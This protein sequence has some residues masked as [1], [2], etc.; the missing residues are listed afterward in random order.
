MHDLEEEHEMN[1]YLLQQEKD[2]RDK[3]DGMIRKQD[4]YSSQPA[5]AVKKPAF[6]EDYQSRSPVTGGN[7]TEAKLQNI[8][9]ISRKE[10][11]LLEQLNQL[12]DMKKNLKNR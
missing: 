1:K 5:F 4:R 7:K 12:R 10:E 6:M 2:L 3:M 9:Q 11:Q 8:E